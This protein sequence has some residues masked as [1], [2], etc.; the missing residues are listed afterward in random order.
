MKKAG[1]HTVPC[2]IPLDKDWQIKH[3][4]RATDK[5]VLPTTNNTVSDKGDQQPES[6]LLLLPLNPCKRSHSDLEI[7]AIY[8]NAVIMFLYFLHTI[9]LQRY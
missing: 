2:K 4:I 7:L 5:T 9:L 3:N 1:Y 6:A 8:D